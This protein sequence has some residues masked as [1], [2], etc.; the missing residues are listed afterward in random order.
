MPLKKKNV[1]ANKIMWVFVLFSL[2]D[3]MKNRPGIDLELGK[4]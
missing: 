4:H 1:L 2:P 3:G